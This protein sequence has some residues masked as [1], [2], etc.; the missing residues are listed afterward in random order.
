MEEKW[1]HWLKITRKEP[2]KMILLFSTGTFKKTET[3]SKLDFHFWWGPESE[4]TPTTETKRS[5]RDQP[6]NNH[7]KKKNL[8]AYG[9]ELNL[10]GS[11]SAKRTNSVSLHW[12]RDGL[13][14][15][16]N[17]AYKTGTSDSILVTE[18]KFSLQLKTKHSMRWASAAMLLQQLWVVSSSKNVGA[19]ITHWL[20]KWKIDI[21]LSIPSQTWK[22]YKN[23]QEHLFKSNY[24]F[25]PMIS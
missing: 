8:E 15:P 6:T 22:K 3:R 14:C 16:S 5:Q 13:L 11:K 10:L 9:E 24:T 4:I 18:A 20:Q 12:W 21:V 25:H 7:Q 2:R 23:A 19:Y 1:N 17:R